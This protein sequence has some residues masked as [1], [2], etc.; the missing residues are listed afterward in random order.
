MHVW[1]R[2]EREKGRAAAG[3]RNGRQRGWAFGEARALMS[4]LRAPGA[5]KGEPPPVEGRNARA[6]IGGRSG[7]KTVSRYH[8]T[9]FTTDRT[10]GR[11][12][13]EVSFGR[14]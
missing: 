8:E 1:S 13:V 2:L 7:I 10:V 11:F 14:A 3:Q 6:V 12:H 5:A 9:V 4:P